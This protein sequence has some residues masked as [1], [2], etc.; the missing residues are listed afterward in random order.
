MSA[1]MSEEDVR[2]DIAALAAVPVSAAELS[3]A[4]LGNAGARL[5]GVALRVREAHADLSAALRTAR[6]AG[7]STDSSRGDSGLL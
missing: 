6:A 2:A 4:G 1:H 5:L 3:A 7:V